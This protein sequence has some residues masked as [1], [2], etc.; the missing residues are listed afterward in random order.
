MTKKELFTKAHEMTR[1]IKAE[2]PEI[3]YRAQFSICLKALN[4]PADEQV[5]ESVEENIENKIEEKAEANKEEFKMNK[6]LSKKVVELNGFTR[7][8]A[9]KIDGNKMFGIIGKGKF[10]WDFTNR[11]LPAVEIK[12]GVDKLKA[13]QYARLYALKRLAMDNIQLPIKTRKRKVDY[14]TLEKSNG[15]W[16]NCFKNGYMRGAV[17]GVP[18]TWDPSKYTKAAVV[19]EPGFKGTISQVIDTDR[20]KARLREA[21]F[22]S[23]KH[24]KE[25]M[26]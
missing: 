22:K 6:I 10:V 21:G 18:F 11:E 23:L 24:L 12:P 1:K 5:K 17:D 8:V 26:A 16:I 9:I 4:E 3:D 13:A 19:T 15:V 14:I 20:I 2:F 7:E 25:S